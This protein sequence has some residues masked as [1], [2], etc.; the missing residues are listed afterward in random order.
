[1][2]LTAMNFCCGFSGRLLLDTKLSSNA[3]HR[4]LIACF[5]APLK[6]PAAGKR[7]KK[8]AENNNRR[9]NH[10]EVCQLTYLKQ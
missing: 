9:Q 8:T 5:D 3:S 10:T 2:T 6:F 1:M 7:R 4:V